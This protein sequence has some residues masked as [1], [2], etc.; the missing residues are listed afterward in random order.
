MIDWGANLAIL[1]LFQLHSAGVVAMRGGYLDF[2]PSNLTQSPGLQT[3]AEAARL[4]LKTMLESWGYG[5]C[6][7]NYNPTLRRLSQEDQVI[8]LVRAVAG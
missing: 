3:E 8:K 4:L 5:G 1:V 7:N 2:F 6:G